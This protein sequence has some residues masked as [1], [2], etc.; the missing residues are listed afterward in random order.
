MVRLDIAAKTKLSEGS[1]FRTIKELPD[2]DFIS[3][4]QPYIN[5]KKT[6]VYELT[7]LYSLFYLKFIKPNKK[8]GKNTWEY[9]SAQ[10]GFAAWSGYAFENICMMHI[11]QIKKALGISGVYTTTSSWMFRGNDTLPGTQI[12]MIIDR[13]DQ[14]I[15]LCE[16]KFTRE[17]FVIT[18]SYA[19]QLRMKKSVFKQATQ[20][21]KLIFTTLLTTF[22]ALKNQHYPGEIDNEITMDKLFKPD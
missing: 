6:S 18:K 7:D 21:K 2:C 3:V 14:T 17:N 10:S 1:L 22:P 4:Y 11:D 13:A 8:N 16:A 15:N 19:T 9:L 12:D 20:T 5:K